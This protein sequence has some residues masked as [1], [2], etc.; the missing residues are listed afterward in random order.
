VLGV[1]VFLWAVWYRP[2][3]STLVT[4]PPSTREEPAE[5]APRR[6]RGRI[7]LQCS[8]LVLQSAVAAAAA[9]AAAADGEESDGSDDDDSDSSGQILAC[10][11]LMD[12]ILFAVALWR[13]ADVG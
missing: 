5:V 2:P 6:S 3:V 11:V 7:V 13:R 4:R 12:F 8:T 9:A 1:P 10:C